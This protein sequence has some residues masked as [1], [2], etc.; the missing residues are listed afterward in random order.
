MPPLAPKPGYYGGSKDDYINGTMVMQGA[1]TDPPRLGFTVRRQLHRWVWRARYTVSNFWRKRLDNASRLAKEN[2]DLGVWPRRLLHVPSMTSY[3]WK[4]GNWYGPAKSPRYNA[5]SYTWGRW[6][7]DDSDQSDV[8]AIEIKG[9]QWGIPRID[10]KHFTVA[11]FHTAITFATTERQRSRRLIPEGPKTIEYVWLDI[12]C[13][14]Q[15]ITVSKSSAEIGRQAQIFGQ[16]SEL[17]IWVPG[18]DSSVLRDIGHLVHGPTG[19]EGSIFN[20]SLSSG[21]LID[22]SVF[23]ES[24]LGEI[25]QLLG[26][27]WFSS[28]WTLQEAFLL[29]QADGLFVGRDQNED[30]TVRLCDLKSFYNRCDE[31]LKT[32]VAAEASTQDESAQQSLRQLLADMNRAGLAAVACENGIAVLSAANDRICTREEDRIYGIQQIFGFRLGT[33]VDPDN[34]YTRAQLDQQFNCA[35]LETYP[36]LSQLHNFTTPC[37]FGSGWRPNTSSVARKTSVQQR[38]LPMFMGRI[39]DELDSLCTLSTAIVAEQ[40]L[41]GYFVG[42]LCKLETLEER[43]SCVEQDFRWKHGLSVGRDFDRLSMLDVH[44]DESDQLRNSP[45]YHGVGHHLVP[46]GACQRA[47][48]QWLLQVS[49]ASKL[50][51]LLLGP[52]HSEHRMFGLLLLSRDGVNA[53]SEEHREGQF[54]QRLGYCEW[55]RTKFLFKHFDDYE[56][57][58]LEGK[59]HFP[60]WVSEEDMQLFQGT[61]ADWVSAEGYFG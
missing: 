24:L 57:W 30:P 5:I 33:T 44:L 40:H 41:W 20:G 19:D 4:P 60:R 50:Y 37:P 15:R 38:L 49:P 51:V 52:K 18:L 12:A 1:R 34:K 14:D 42:S 23:N 8:K 46:S 56:E 13:I 48:R 9:I 17:Y 61:S 6:A 10:P 21:R 47:L 11:E 43:I 28:L 54:W 55:W 45:E 29:G 2:L 59:Q 26:N 25:K 36:L 53:M 35:L 58:P 27:P 3:E 39:N 16:A 22:K 32:M 7:L 31:A